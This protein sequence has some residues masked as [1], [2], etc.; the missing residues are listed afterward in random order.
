MRILSE[1]VTRSDNPALARNIVNRLWWMMMGRGLVDPLDMHHSGNPPSHPE[2][3]D[4]LAHDMVEHGYDI[5][6]LLRELALTETYQRSSHLPPGE[7]EP[8]LRASYR[9]ALERPISAEQWLTILREASGE[10]LPDAQVM[11]QWRDRFEKVFAN[12]PK[13][14]EV[15]VAPTVKAAL[16]LSNDS[17]VLSWFERREGNLVDRLCK[18]ES[19]TAVLDEAY[20]SVLTRLPTEQERLEME[21]FLRRSDI[22]R[23]KAVGMLAWALAASTEFLVIH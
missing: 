3:L 22:S 2:L 4:M 23:D 1:A 21:R 16:F 9:T 13:E 5:K 20:L 8:P 17:L 7:D 15:Q 14:P 18:L 10:Q 6:W 12:P 19:D 11:D